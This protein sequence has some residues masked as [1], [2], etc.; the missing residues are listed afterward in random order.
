MVPLEEGLL[1]FQSVQMA[2]W[3]QECLLVWEAGRKVGEQESGSYGVW[4]WS[5]S[6]TGRAQETEVGLGKEQPEA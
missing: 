6:P 3:E 1:D 4:I 2:C 5:S